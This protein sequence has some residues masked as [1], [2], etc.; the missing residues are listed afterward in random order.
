MRI[1]LLAASLTGL[2]VLG[3]SN[4]LAHD[5]ED[6]VTAVERG[7]NAD[8]VHYDHHHY[9]YDGYG[10]SYVAHHDHHYVVPNEDYGYRRPY[11]RHHRRHRAAFSFFFGG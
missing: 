4:A 6:G 8:V 1:P 7:Y 5:Y 9:G 3:A 11:Y 10:D 2:L